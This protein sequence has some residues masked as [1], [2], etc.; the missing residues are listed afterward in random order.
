MTYETILY[1]VQDGIATITLNRPDT[2][3]KARV[4]V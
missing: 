4:Q 2:Y 1:D 3:N